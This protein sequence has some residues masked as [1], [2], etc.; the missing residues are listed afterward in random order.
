MLAVQGPQAAEILGTLGLDVSGL[1]YY[2]FVDTAADHEHLLHAS[3]EQVTPVKVALS[4]LV[5]PNKLSH[6]GNSWSMPVPMPVA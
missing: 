4:A 6:Y 2:R 1:R 5:L 3:V